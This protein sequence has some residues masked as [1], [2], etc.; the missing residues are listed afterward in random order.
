MNQVYAGAF[1]AIDGSVVAYGEERIVA[2]DHEF[3]DIASFVPAGDGWLRYPQLADANSARL[4]G[5]P[6]SRLPRARYLLTLGAEGLA[7]GKA[8]EPAN[9]EPAYLRAKV[10][11]IPPGR[12]SPS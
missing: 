3:D 12:T 11:E 10:A 4:A 5:E 8:V 1:E 2:C 6:S 9:L 7:A